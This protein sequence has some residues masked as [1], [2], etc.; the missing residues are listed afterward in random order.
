MRSAR[1]R[2]GVAGVWD[3]LTGRYFKT[4]KKNE[5]EVFFSQQRDR[6]QRHDLVQ[7]QLEERQKLQRDIERTREGHAKQI[8]SLYRDAADYRRMAR[9]EQ[10]EREGIDRGQRGNQAKPRGPELSL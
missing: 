2:K 8:L 1:V 9:G 4:R 6:N 5:V 3:I 7:S 10:F